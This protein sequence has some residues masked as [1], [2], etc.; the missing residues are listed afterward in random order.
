[1]PMKIRIIASV[2]ALVA[3][4]ACKAP[5]PKVQAV[6][7]NGEVAN[8][9][10]THAQT[11]AAWRAAQVGG[12]VNYLD[13]YETG[14]ES[15][16]RIDLVNKSVF[17]MGADAGVTID[18]FV[19]DPNQSATGVT[20]AVSK[21]L[22]RFVSGSRGATPE[23]VSLRTPTASIGI[24]GTIAE[25]V[26]GPQ[27]VE[28]LAQA[29]G[30][31]TLTGDPATAAVIILREGAIDVTVGAKTASLTQPGQA[32]AVFGQQL[33]DPFFLTEPAN[34]WFTARLPGGPPPA[35]PPASGPPPPPPVI[36]PPPPPGKGPRPVDN[37][38]SGPARP[39]LSGPVSGPV[40]GPLSG[41]VPG[42]LSGPVPGPLSGP[43]PGPLSG[44]APGPLSGP[45][46]PV[47]DKPQPQ[48]PAPTTY[49]DK[50]L[51][52]QKPDKPVVPVTVP[53]KPLPGVATGKPPA[54]VV[55][56]PSKPAPGGASLS[57]VGQPTV[58]PNPAPTG[59]VVRPGP[60]IS[61]APS[62]SNNNRPTGSGNTPPSSLTAVPATN[63]NGAPGTTAK[64]GAGAPATGVVAR[65]TSSV[66]GTNTTTPAT[67]ANG[68]TP[69]KTGGAATTA[70]GAPATN[71]TA[72]AATT[73]APKTKTKIK[74]PP[75]KLNPKARD[76]NAP[77]PPLPVIR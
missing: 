28:F 11:E 50:P 30:L 26:V 16:L 31:T 49:P 33:S 19:Y 15:H 46:K 4:A 34:Q 24:R 70:T 36:V 9:V 21:G 55:V 6:G 38:G 66:P 12:Q 29:P 77:D 35:P 8:T 2:I 52:P 10:R 72:P 40:P 58:A 39:V 64:T 59:T 18:K 63:S 62:T 67:T 69:P 60:S 27:A 3:L 56:A 61:V 32:V 48:K 22:F 23:T 7:I 41:P 44:P 1:M 20:F 13:A 65:P 17:T 14:D 5:P 53:N 76:P 68:Q 25:G 75:L 45:V 37:Q 73:A 71:V 57:S 42:P 47:I 51:P 43:V 54:G 74:L